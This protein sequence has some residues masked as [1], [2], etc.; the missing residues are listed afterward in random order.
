[1]AEQSS[2]SFKHGRLPLE[3]IRKAQA[4]GMKTTQEAHAIAMQYGKTLTSIMAAAGLTTKA[5]RAK[6]V[7]NMHQ[8][9]YAHTNP[10]TSEEDMQSYYS[11]HMLHYG[12]HKDEEEYLELWDEIC[13]YWKESVSGTKDMSSKAMVGHVMTCRDSFTQAAQTWCNVKDIHVFGC[14]I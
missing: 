14:V 3:A 1:D 11:R 13:E 12:A 5:M 8:A 2:Q 4:L 7:W 10:K 6:L 9:W